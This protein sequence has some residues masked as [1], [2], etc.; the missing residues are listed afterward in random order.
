MSLGLI[1]S[2]PVK[3]QVLFLLDTE[4]KEIMFF[5]GVETLEDLNPVFTSPSMTPFRWTMD[6]KKES[7]A[8][9]HGKVVV[10]M[11]EVKKLEANTR[12]IT[13]KRDGDSVPGGFWQCTVHFEEGSKELSIEGSWV[14]KMCNVSNKTATR[15]NLLSG[16]FPFLLLIETFF[17]LVDPPD[18][19]LLLS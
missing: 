11:M 1:M 8:V 15:F 17:A 19:F 3:A 6:S 12:A 16:K 4:T 7:F 10:A 14:G 18:L 9:Y 2:P 5:Q 13:V